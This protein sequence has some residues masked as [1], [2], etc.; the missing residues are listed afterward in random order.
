LSKGVNQIIWGEF[1][2]RLPGSQSAD[3]VI[4]AIDST[5]W[6]VFAEDACLDRI[7]KAFRDVRP[8]A[9]TIV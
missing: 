1:Q 5:L 3:L 9:Y 6:E 2:G 8:T 4:K 7:R